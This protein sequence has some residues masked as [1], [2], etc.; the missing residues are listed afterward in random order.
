MEKKT[1]IQ[2]S[3]NMPLSGVSIEFSESTS[4]NF[5]Y[6]LKTAKTSNS[7]QEC[8]KG[9][10]KW[11]LASW[12]IGEISC[13]IKLANDLDGI[14]NKKVFIDGEEKR[15]AD[16]FSFIRCYSE[17]KSAYNPTEYCFGLDR[18]ELN[19]WGCRNS[20]M[21]WNSWAAWFS[22]GK[23]ENSGLLRKKV[24][25]VFDKKRIEHELKTN[26][27]KYK[28]CPNINFE[29]ILTVLKIF[30]ERVEIS[31]KS[32]W[33]YKEAY[34]NLPGH[35]KVKETE[36]SAFG[37][38]YIREFYASGVVPK[39]AYVGLKILREAIELCGAKK[40]QIEKLLEYNEE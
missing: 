12:P 10:K 23:F 32:D 39:G 25:F 38:G 19:I 11:F 40:I 36:T 2:V 6:A 15:W 1:E 24:Y 29:L 5:S 14:R 18:K 27:F 13:S 4:A 26:L 16:I 34:E 22:Y 21:I 33:K 3:F 17:R 8:K 20:K 37:D 30:P 31:E 28:I 35:I 9:K 7:F